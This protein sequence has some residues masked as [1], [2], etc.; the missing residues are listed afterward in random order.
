MMSSSNGTGNNFKQDKMLS[1]WEIKKLK[2]KWINIHDLK[3]KKNGSKFDLF[4]DK[5]GEIYYKRKTWRGTSNPEY[6][7]Y[8]IND[9]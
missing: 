7:W 6:P 3:P 5:I 8:N 1:S 2:S 9:F 4:K